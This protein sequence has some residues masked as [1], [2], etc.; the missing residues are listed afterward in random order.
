MKKSLAILLLIS[1][2]GCVHY[3]RPSNPANIYPQD[4]IIRLDSDSPRW[5]WDTTCWFFSKDMIDLRKTI[6]YDGNSTHLLVPYANTKYK[7]GQMVIYYHQY[8]LSKD[9]ASIQWTHNDPEIDLPYPRG[10]IW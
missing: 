1:L 8:N 5:G 4:I 3:L 9:T 10:T 7:N 2:C 6:L